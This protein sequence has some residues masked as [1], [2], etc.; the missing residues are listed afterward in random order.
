MIAESTQLMNV[1][2]RDSRGEV[3]TS[4]ACPRAHRH[5]RG[6]AVSDLLSKYGRNPK[7]LVVFGSTLDLLASVTEISEDG[8]VIMTLAPVCEIM[9]Q[10]LRHMGVFEMVGMSHFLTYILHVRAAARIR[11]DQ[12]RLEFL[13]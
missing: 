12:I 13:D 1:A 8:M 10:K 5:S 4:H 6:Q 3:H 7:G 2:N 9:F 11:E